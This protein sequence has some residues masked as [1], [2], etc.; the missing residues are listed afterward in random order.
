M[1]RYRLRPVEIDALQL[2]GEPRLKKYVSAGFEKTQRIKNWREAEEFSGWV[3][4]GNGVEDI[5]AMSDYSPGEVRGAIGPGWWLIKNADG[6][7]WCEADNIFREK[8][9]PISQEC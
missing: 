4:I 5:L 2:I 1:A 7:V 9:E 8:Y 6:V 3:A